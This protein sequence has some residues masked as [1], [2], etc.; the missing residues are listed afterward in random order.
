M[1]EKGCSSVFQQTTAS[2]GLLLAGYGLAGGWLLLLD[3]APVATVVARVDEGCCR[4]GGFPATV[5]DDS[6]KAELSKN[7][8]EKVKKGGAWLLVAHQQ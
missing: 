5:K 1:E 2:C 3:V 7:N 4:A 8:D 6:T